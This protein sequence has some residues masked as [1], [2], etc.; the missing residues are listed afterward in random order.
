MG[1]YRR[2]TTYWFTVTYDGR[3][4]QESLQTDNKKLAEKV[5]A[6]KLVDIVEGHHFEGN[7]GENDEL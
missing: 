1:L 2:G 7:R 4:I 6:K 3:R 5:Y